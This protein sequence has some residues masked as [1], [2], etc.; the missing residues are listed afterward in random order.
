[1]SAIA[2]GRAR[3][4]PLPPDIAKKLPVNEEAERNILGGILL[5]NK[6]FKS[7][8]DV[9]IAADF[10]VRQNQKIFMHM[11]IMADGGR[12]IDLT[13]LVEELSNNGELEA[14]GGA[15]YLA[16]LSDGVPKISNLRFY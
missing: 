14:A 13:M 2:F 4:A 11:V 3:L 7:V 12:P 16:S 1:M 10:S 9:L 8:R 6:S 15:G 5:D